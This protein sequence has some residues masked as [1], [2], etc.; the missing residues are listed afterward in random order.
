MQKPQLNVS[1][2][3]LVQLA[4]HVVSP[5]AHVAE[6]IPCE[7]NGVAAV[8]TV[9]HAPQ[10]AGSETVLTQPVV[11]AVRPTVHVHWPEVQLWPVPQAVLHMPQW[12]R[13]V[14]VV[15]QTLLQLVCPSAQLGPLPPTPPL[16]AVPAV[17][18]P[19]P[20]PDVPPFDVPELLSSSS[21]LLVATSGCGEQLPIQ[22][23]APA[24]TAAYTKRAC[25]AESLTQVWP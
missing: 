4:P 6:H 10:F 17:V 19:V 18:P 14:A 24:A 22:R 5:T 21:S 7:Q 23:S 8:Q 9:P 2:I 11:H 12:R 25:M 1:V 16:G 3:V 15:V 20:V 13:S